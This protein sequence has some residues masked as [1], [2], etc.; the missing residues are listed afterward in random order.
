M[1]IKGN[2]SMKQDMKRLGI[3]MLLYNVIMIAATILITTIINMAAVFCWNM[4]TEAS[5][6]LGVLIQNFSEVSG[7]I[8][9]I[10]CGFTAIYAYRKKDL[11]AYDLKVSRRN[12][13]W[14]VFA[15]AVILVFGVQM[16]YNFL[17]MGAEGLFNLFG[18]TVQGE[19][20]SASGEN[21][22]VTMVIYTVLI[23]PIMEE[24]IFR[25]A[26]MRSLEKYGKVFA[27][28]ASSALFAIY[29]G[30]ILQAF[31]AFTIGLILAYLAEEYSIKWSMLLHIINN[32]AT[33]IMGL[34]QDKWGEH[35]VDIVTNY[36]FGAALAGGLIL[37]LLQRKK[38]AGYIKENPTQAGVVA[39]MCTSIGLIL[40]LVLEMGMAILGIQKL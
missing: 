37:L 30:N 33:E 10:L 17:T 28:V 26:V 24:V 36:L 21:N 3:A 23:G 39:A 40:F 5:Q 31:F 11:F 1:K 12:M 27:I 15:G 4:G 32:G 38:V 22:N 7:Y 20:Q 13:R 35:A 29:H 14:R 2:D 18:Y 8:L 9:G 6:R 25:G 16:L 34:C 19:I